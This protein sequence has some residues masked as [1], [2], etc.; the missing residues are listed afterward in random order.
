M[1]KR[2]MTGLLAISIA[3][4]ASACG[5]SGDDAGR[6]MADIPEA[7]SDA[8]LENDQTQMPDDQAGGIKPEETATEDID[9][10]PEADARQAS[11]GRSLAK[12]MEGRYSYHLGAGDLSEDEYLIMDVESFGDNLYAY[13]GYAMA[14]DDEELSAYSFWVCEFI[15]EEAAELRSPDADGAEVTALSWSIMSNAGK[16]WNSGSR[17]RITLTDEGLVLD[18]FSGSGFPIPEQDTSCLLLK[19]D[20]AEKAFRYLKDDGEAG[21]E[22]LQGVWVL[23]GQ[24][25][26]VYL[27]FAGSNL[28]IYQKHPDREVFFEASGAD[29]DADSISCTGNV[30]GNGGMPYEWYAGY[31]VNGDT[32]Q[33][34]AEGDMMP[35][36]L[37]GEVTLR[38]ISEESVHVTVMDEIR[39]DGESFGLSGYDAVSGEFLYEDGFYGIWTMAARDREGAITEAEK[40]SEQGYHSYV[41]Y[42]PEWEDLNHEPFYC[43][44]TD[45]YLKKEQAESALEEIQK[46]GYRDAYIKASGKRRYMTIDYTNFGD[47]DVLLNSDQVII[48]G[49]LCDAVRSWQPLMSE[50]TA[51]HRMDL[52]IDRDT[53]FDDSCDLQYFGNYREGDTPFEWFRRNAEL[54]NTDPDRYMAQGPALT[55]VFEVGIKGSHIDRFFGSYWWD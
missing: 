23:E 42:S 40:L 53:V 32:L 39:F 9:V 33:L 35:E 46:A 8:A 45:R 48:R 4:S 55:G 10:K 24:T 30:L 2:M 38:R 49:V 31:H 3:L 25:T 34:A 47:A 28:I 18:G 54:M 21:D 41:C 6:S 16:Y 1:K 50:E 5:K 13:C 7:A 17:G 29:I 44:T 37:A 51:D 14:E 22:R 12:R 20:R 26:P 36:E 19:D 27:R 52:I 43:V 15:P 11:A